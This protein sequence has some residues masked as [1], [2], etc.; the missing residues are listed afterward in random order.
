MTHLIFVDYPTFVFLI[1]AFM[2]AALFDQLVYGEMLQTS[3]LAK[4]FAVT[5]LAYTRCASNN[6]VRIF[7]SH[8]LGG[9]ITFYLEATTTESG[10][11]D[12]RV[13]SM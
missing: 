10:S 2:A 8:L 13:M 1:P 3:S 9:C 11:F 7:P 6:Y 12:V 4:Q 5:C